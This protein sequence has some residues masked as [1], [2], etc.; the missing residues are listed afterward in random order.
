MPTNVLMPQMGESIA[1]GTIVRWVKNVGEPVGRD[2]PLFEIST[3]KVDAE[4]PSPAGGVLLEI[5][6][7]AG[8]T[9]PVHSVVAVIGGEG[10]TVTP[11][12]VPADIGPVDWGGISAVGS[13]GPVPGAVPGASTLRRPSPVVRRLAAEHGVDLAEIA[14][15]GDA[16]RVTKAD[17]LAFVAG[18]D[19][20]SVDPTAPPK[21]AVAAGPGG[22][23]EPMSVMRRR[24]AEHMVTSRRT[25]AHVHTVFEVDFSRIAAL[26]AAVR[27]AS[28]GAPG[29]L[30]YIT[31]AVAD[32]LV[33]MPLV[34]A[35]VDGDNV[36]YH[37]QV[38][39]GIAVALDWG[40][41]VP[42][43]K[44]A[45]RLSVDEIDAAIA[46]L[47]TRAR[48]KQLSPEDVAGGTFTITNPGRLG[49]VFGMPI[50]NQPQSAI[51]CVGAVEKRP[52]VVDDAVVS[53]LRAFLTV[54]FDHR[55]IDG[56]LADRFLARIKDTLE[57]FPQETGERRQ[58]TGGA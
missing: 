19:G 42:V 52:V 51:L 55:L 16:G 40:L 26:R 45:D 30:S 10:E 47:A 13:R 8:K 31:A 44:Q 49:S 36:V 24:I 35:S 5:R 4:I 27:L 1:E 41:I 57:A 38:N 21:P 39:L 32:A 37:E 33:A 25:S 53:R 54:G 34:N 3:D 28:V 6:A 2:E 29:Y 20:S 18:R 56:A 58:E 17:V 7:E 9:V 43:I 22:R 46:D 48:S 14:G 50:I 15:T 11:A 12:P 23:I